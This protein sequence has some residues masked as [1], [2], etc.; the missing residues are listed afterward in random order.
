M[1]VF[2]LKIKILNKIE[3]FFTNCEYIYELNVSFS[4]E[5]RVIVYC[6]K[7]TCLFMTMHTLWNCG[8]CL[9]L[10]IN[11]EPLFSGT[12]MILIFFLYIRIRNQ[13]RSNQKVLI[14]G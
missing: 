8:V 9:T 13:H 6:D 5:K 11:S 12:D 3:N 10:L 2:G 4:A 7:C 1:V 14:P